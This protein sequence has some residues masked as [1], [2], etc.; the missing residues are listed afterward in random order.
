MHN[1]R[2]ALF[3]LGCVIFSFLWI[4]ELNLKQYSLQ[5]IGLLALIFFVSKYLRHAHHKASTRIPL[6]FIQSDLLRLGLIIVASLVI[7]IN[8]GASN[9]VYFPLNYIF[10][11]AIVFSV[12]PVVGVITTLAITLLYYLQN[13]QIELGLFFRL[14]SLPIVHGAFLII[15]TQYVELELQKKEMGAKDRELRTLIQA[16]ESLES[17][18]ES[19]V[20]PKL[21]ALEEGTGD[22][23]LTPSVYRRQLSLLETEIEK[24][25]KKIR[26][27]AS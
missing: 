26:Q 23:D 24:V 7:V 6:S 12:S 15:K 8:T 14:L 9:S 5:L 13:P 20:T 19:F 27:L 3:L 21:K 16:E 18:L 11:F 17:F 22:A 1:L 2:D 4:H 25:L 10:L